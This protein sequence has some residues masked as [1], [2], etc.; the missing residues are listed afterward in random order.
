MFLKNSKQLGLDNL[1]LTDEGARLSSNF[2]DDKSYFRNEQITDF[3]TNIN[4]LNNKKIILRNT[5]Q[6]AMN[7]TNK[8]LDMPYNG[9]L[10]RMVDYTIPFVQLTLNGISNYYSPAINQDTS[11]SLEWY[12]LKSN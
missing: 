5:N 9:T 3:K 11:R 4:S 7:I 12:R 1:L 10:H 8:I 2:K 6:Y